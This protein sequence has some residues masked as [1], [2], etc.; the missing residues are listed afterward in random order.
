MLE[1]R[2]AAI[3]DRWLFTLGGGEQVAFTYAQVLSELGYDVSLLTHKKFDPDL[4]KKKMGVSLKNIA[5]KFLP[6]FS[7]QEISGLSEKYDLFIN[8]SHLDYFPNRSKLGI[9]S[10]FFP[11]QINLSFLG[12]IKRAFLIPIFRKLFIYP[13]RF[14]GFAYDEYANGKILKWLSP[15]SSIIFK[16]SIVYFEIQL[17]FPDFTFSVLDEI[18][19]L[20]D[21]EKV[22]FTKRKIESHTNMITYGFQPQGAKFKIFT[23]LLPE[24]EY[25][26][27]IALM[28]LTIPNIRFA[29]YNLFKKQ[30]PLWEMRLH[31]GPS[32]TKT[33]DLLSYDRVITIS[34]FCQKWIWRYWKIKADILYPPVNTKVFAA[35]KQ[36]MNIILH[37]GRFFVTGH[38]KKQLELVA[39]FRQLCDEYKNERWE[40]HFVGSIAE[41]QIHQ[42]YLKTVRSLAQGYPVHF[43]IDAPFNELKKLF[44]QAKIYWHATGF[45]ENEEETPISFEHFGITTVEAMASGCVPV[46]INAG[47]QKEIVT[48]ESGFKWETIDELISNSLKLMQDPKLLKK[49]SRA[50]IERSNY[51]SKENFKKR[52]TK[53]I[54]QTR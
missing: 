9:L 30:F 13:S 47:G 41:G 8:T 25:S 1:Q 22:I 45:G 20:L 36:K 4:A 18:T 52:F 21:G 50:A 12:Y 6:E 23:I 29:L 16:N 46:V 11:G 34:K 26:N 49:Y 37:V 32:V 38:S 51:F 43:H 28:T 14:E 24:N 48:E 42:N 15:E 39:A 19:F 7:S 27:K 10:V 53:L 3:Y 5:I 40:L 31:G 17:Y 54:F 35:S 33:A 44:A 2:T